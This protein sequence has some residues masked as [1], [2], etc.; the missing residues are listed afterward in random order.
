MKKLKSKIQSQEIFSAI[1][2]YLPSDHSDTVSLPSYIKKHFNKLP[3]GAKILDLE[4][5]EMNI[6]LSD[7]KLLF[8]IIF[9]AVIL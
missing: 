3:V 4:R 7:N 8:I 6:I 2:K 1:C 5:I 9:L